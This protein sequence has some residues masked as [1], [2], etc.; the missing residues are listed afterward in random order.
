MSIPFGVTVGYASM[1]KSPVLVF[2]RHIV[3]SSDNVVYRLEDLY[4]LRD[5]IWAVFWD[6]QIEMLSSNIVGVVVGVVGI[7]NVY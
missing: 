1:L 3:I 5:S 2:S 4:V 7:S 6:I